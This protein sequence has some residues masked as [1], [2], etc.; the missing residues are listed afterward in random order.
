MIRAG[1]QHIEASDQSPITR[2]TVVRLGV[3]IILPL[4]PLVLTMVPLE[5]IVDQAI[6]MFI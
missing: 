5:H 6:D 1:G 3:L 2:S 4:L